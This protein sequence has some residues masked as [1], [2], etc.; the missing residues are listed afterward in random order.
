MPT[1][2]SFYNDPI[3]QFPGSSSIVLQ[4]VAQT[5]TFTVPLTLVAYSPAMPTFTHG[6]A[7]MIPIDGGIGAGVA[8][9]PSIGLTQVRMEGFI[10]TP[11]AESADLYL[12]SLTLDGFRQTYADIVAAYWEGRMAGW[13]RIQPTLFRDPY[14]RQFDNPV[15][16]DFQASYIEAAPQRTNFTLVLK[17]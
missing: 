3:L 9:T 5:G 2:T 6:Q 16:M 4:G 15:I 13:Q 11:M 12:S 10:D 14:G 8:L 17:V 1:Q 7:T